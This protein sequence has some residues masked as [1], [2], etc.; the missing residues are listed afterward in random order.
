M[1]PSLRT[2][3]TAFPLQNDEIAKQCRYI[4]EALASLRTDKSERVFIDLSL[5]ELLLALQNRCGAQTE[6][7][8]RFSH[9]HTRCTI[10]VDLPGTPCNVLKDAL[11]GLGYDEIILPVLDRQIVYSF[12]ENCNHYDLQIAVHPRMSFT[13][14]VVVALAAAVLCGLVGRTILPEPL[15]DAFRSTLSA[16]SAIMLGLMRM[17]A[18]PLVFCG[19]INGITGCG[20]LRRLREIG[21]GL[22]RHLLLSLFLILLL[23]LAVSL[24]VFPLSSSSDAGGIS[25]FQ[26]ILDAI[27]SFFPNDLITPFQDGNGAQIILLA[28]FA[29]VILLTIGEQTARI[30]ITF[31]RLYDAL[32][33]ALSF[34]S[35]LIPVLIFALAANMLLDSSFTDGF[36]L[37]AAIALD[38][39]IAAVLTFAEILATARKLGLGFK[40]VFLSAWPIM[41]K[42]LLTASAISA[43]PETEQALRE[44]FKLSREDSA[45]GL[46]FATG[47]FGAANTISLPL[48]TVFCAHIA[49]I[50]ISAAW[51]FSLAVQCYVFSLAIP[52]STG[53]MLFVL[54]ALFT[55]FGI[56]MEYL[57]IG[58]TLLMIV[59]YP[60]TSLRA[61]AT[62]LELAREY[63]QKK[64]KI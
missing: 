58:T 3:T 60:S 28:V 21:T 46:S 29:G 55:S 63:G 38:L 18:V 52:S 40:E 41:L 56:P 37:L 31:R 24:A 39:A 11:R 57:A 5:E 62:L 7:T 49:G 22:V 59:D 17:L 12:S 25:I 23:T 42:G 8:L 64:S 16:F 20:N 19:M 10:R 48:V 45:F 43:Y 9:H 1:T 53:G 2:E 35:R 26:S 27:V 36:L 33:I 30:T 50:D 32:M 4:G 51:V 47:M 61:T 6:V 54:S 14:S 13:V 44:D 15:T 34:I